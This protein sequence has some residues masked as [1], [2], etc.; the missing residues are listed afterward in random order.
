M[1]KMKWINS[2]FIKI[3]NP[4]CCERYIDNSDFNIVV[5][6][7]AF[8]PVIILLDLR[9]I[10]FLIGLFWIEGENIFKFTYIF[11]GKCSFINFF[12]FDII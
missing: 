4:I 9:F 3:P 5:L 2:C 12:I 6:P 10:L 7:E 8:G 1:N 11:S